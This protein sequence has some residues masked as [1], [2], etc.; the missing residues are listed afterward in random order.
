MPSFAATIWDGRLHGRGAVDD[1]GSAIASV[2]ALAAARAALAA[3]G[4][5][6]KNTILL[7]FR[8]D[9]DCNW[10]DM[11]I[12]RSR[13]SLASS[14]FSPDGDFPIVNSEKGILA[15]RLSSSQDA[16]GI[17]QSA[18]GGNR[19]TRCRHTRRPS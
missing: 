9:E 13:H 14:G 1:K 19:Q 5:A 4:A 3:C 11:E 6:P 10:Q 17:L 2:F 15:I 18:A 16:N 7:M 12:Y 8:T